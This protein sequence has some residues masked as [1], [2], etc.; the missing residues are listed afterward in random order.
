MEVEI[1]LFEHCGTILSAIILSDHLK[2]FGA[3]E[4][5]SR[6]SRSKQWYTTLFSNGSIYLSVNFFYLCLHIA[7]DFNS[8]KNFRLLIYSH[9]LAFSW[10]KTTW[11]I[12]CAS[13]Y[14]FSHQKTYRE[15]TY[16]I[17]A[18]MRLLTSDFD[19]ERPFF[20]MISYHFIS[21]TK[22]YSQFL[23]KNNF[24]LNWIEMLPRTWF[25]EV[26]Y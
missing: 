18:K 1:D 14:F 6:L 17:F 24:W 21:L 8:P 2:I 5:N 10:L 26:F 25:L 20:W 22:W 3:F 11:Y 15:R 23:K 13:G 16:S 4:C 19:G 9:L 7:T 12:K